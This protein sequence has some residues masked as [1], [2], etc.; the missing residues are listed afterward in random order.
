[1]PGTF[2]YSGK[3]EKNL[4]IGPRCTA[5]LA[6]AFL[7]LPACSKKDDAV[8]AET[9]AAPAEGTAATGASGEKREHEHERGDGGREH[10]H[11]KP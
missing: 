2:S 1:V 8:P 9:T 4:F 10:E 3:M 6:A 5:L 7:L 11:E